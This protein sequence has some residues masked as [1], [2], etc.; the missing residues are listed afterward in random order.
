[1]KTEWVRKRNYS[2]E[3]E[4]MRYWGVLRATEA[5]KCNNS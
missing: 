4:K 5:Q 1:M 3:E 2:V